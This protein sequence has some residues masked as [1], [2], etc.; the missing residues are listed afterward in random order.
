MELTIEQV[1]QMA[2]AVNLEIPEA[3]ISSVVIR[4]SSLLT[5]MEDVER[6]LGDQMDLTDPVPPVFP[7]E[8][9]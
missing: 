9:F 8:D 5:A 3:E 4:L 2:K 1:R 7:R 6:E